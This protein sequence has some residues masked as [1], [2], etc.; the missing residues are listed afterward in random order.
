MKLVSKAV[1]SLKEL[2][3]SDMDEIVRC[4]I[5]VWIV[6]CKLMSFEGLE[7]PSLS[8]VFLAR[9][10]LRPTTQLANL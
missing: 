8:Q 10:F 5:A 3:P 6:L 9:F 4:P 2:F 1:I 7:L